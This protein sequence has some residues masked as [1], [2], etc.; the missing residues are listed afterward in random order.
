MRRMY[1]SW[2]VWVPQDRL[3]FL[4]VPVAPAQDAHEPGLSQRVLF[5]VASLDVRFLDSTPVRPCAE[6][7][8]GFDRAKAR[9]A[10]HAINWVA[11]NCLGQEKLF[12]ISLADFDHLFLGRQVE[13][14]RPNG[15]HIFVVADDDAVAFVDRHRCEDAHAIISLE[16]GL[17][18]GLV[19]ATHPFEQSLVPDRLAGLFAVGFVGWIN[20]T[21]EVAGR[22]CQAADD[23][24][25]ACIS[26]NIVDLLRERLLRLFQVCVERPDVVAPVDLSLSRGSNLIRNRS[27]SRSKNILNILHPAHAVLGHHPEV[28]IGS[29]ELCRQ[30]AFTRQQR[31][32]IGCVTSDITLGGE[33]FL[34]GVEHEGVEL[35]PPSPSL[36]QWVSRQVLPTLYSA[37]MGTLIL[38]KQARLLRHSASDIT[39]DIV[40]ISFHLDLNF[41]VNNSHDLGVD[42]LVLDF[43][44]N[45]LEPFLGDH[46][47]S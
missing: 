2:L 11:G 4:F 13:L 17:H 37:S 22:I 19:F 18:D 39:S 46:G 32:L 47:S 33:R 42:A 27:V 21:P 10:F 38:K 15:P 12:S 1:S 29:V 45:Q 6:G 31:N 30:Q 7:S 35:P 23:V 9:Q 25:D 16:L 40:S 26:Y 3:S 41:I 34:L 44:V 20:I 43:L 24:R 8:L 5:G 14:R 28:A 36:H